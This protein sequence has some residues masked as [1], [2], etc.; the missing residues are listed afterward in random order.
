M[1]Q[2]QPF[3]GPPWSPSCACSQSKNLAGEEDEDPELA[4]ALK[5]SMQE[6]AGGEGAIDLT[7]EVNEE[8]ADD[9]PSK[10]KCGLGFH[11]VV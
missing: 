2:H 6:S 3:P 1:L 8:K 5:L 10:W 4:E 9:D 11:V 7:S